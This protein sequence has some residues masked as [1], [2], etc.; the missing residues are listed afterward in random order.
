LLL[1]RREKTGPISPGVWE[2]LATTTTAATV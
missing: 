2:A 1:D